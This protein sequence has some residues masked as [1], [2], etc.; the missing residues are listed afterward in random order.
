M[1]KRTVEILVIILS[2][3]WQRLVGV[4]WSHSIILASSR[5]GRALGPA[6]RDLVMTELKSLINKISIHFDDSS[7]IQ[8]I[9]QKI[10]TEPWVTGPLQPS[11]FE[12]FMSPVSGPRN[13]FR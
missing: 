7:I 1:E 5:K 12:G 10:H 9:R 13:R 3:H 2:I 11:I 4:T 8:A 6:V